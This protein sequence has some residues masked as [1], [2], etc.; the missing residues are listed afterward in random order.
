MLLGVRACR[1]DVVRSERAHNSLGVSPCFSRWMSDC[2]YVGT[3]LNGV[4]RRNVQRMNKARRKGSGTEKCEVSQTVN[5][6]YVGSRNFVIL[7]RSAGVGGFEY[8]SD[9]PRCADY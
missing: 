5:L 7:Q 8:D 4:L 3:D 9:L 1:P 6:Y 2:K